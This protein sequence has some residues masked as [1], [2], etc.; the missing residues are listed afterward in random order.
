M[1]A[2]RH[3]LTD[4]KRSQRGSVLSGVLIMTAFI[5]II[6]GALM[7][8]LSTNFLLSRDL[9]LRLD[10]EAT[11]NSTL[12]TAMNQMETIPVRAGCP[13]LDAVSINGRT[14][15]P[16]YLSCG[17]TVAERPQV[18]GIA[19]GSA[20]N[21]DGAHSVIPSLGQD[22]YLVG[23]ASGTVF[24]FTVGRSSPNWSMR[25]PG[26]VSGPPIAMHDPN[27]GDIDVS[28]LVPIAVR[29]A[30]P[31]GCA[32]GACVARVLHDVGL[33]PADI[34]YMAA[35]GPVTAQP[36]PGVNNSWVAFF[37]DRS[38]TLFAYGADEAHDCG[39]Q[40]RISDGGQPVVAG[41]AVFAGRS[42][43]NSRS[44]E[45]YVVTSD[46]SSSVLRHFEFTIQR[47]VASFEEAGALQLPAPQAVGLSVDRSTLPARIAVTFAGGGL[48]LVQ[49]GSGYGMSLLGERQLAAGISDA[50]AW[51]CGA[52]P[53]VIGV[54]DAA[55]LN[56]LNANLGLVAAYNAPASA[57]TSPTA[58][59]AG[60]WFFGAADG[61]LYEVPAIQST[62][63]VIAFGG[64][65]L[66]NVTSSAQVGV[67]GNWVCAYLA[68]GSGHVYMA[69]LDARTAVVSACIASSG[70]CTKV[71]PRLQAHVDVGSAASQ[72]A[73]RIEGWSYHAA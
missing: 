30:A 43:G 33:P 11:L 69:Q 37:G 64:G 20:F 47:G 56:V 55:G 1:K 72:Q 15:L 19:S 22:L 65:A 10:N 2:L 32:S 9:V 36:A 61:N 27:A 54:V 21:V 46:G 12:E 5:A 26:A 60:D 68:T 48:A 29:S 71:N 39:L 44:D 23:D 7:T 4:S 38:G 51:C 67:C 42:T 66:G 31:P 49:I 13:T 70:S 17:L 58:D 16:A 41:P 8:M 40:V 53:S 18:A 57:S 3:L 6:S 63:T 34:C 59:G 62:P 73:V 50:P 35:D 45:V 14:G 25:L 28:D 52:T 24:E